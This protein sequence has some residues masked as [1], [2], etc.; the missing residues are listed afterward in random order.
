[1]SLETL[2]IK[3]YYACHFLKYFKV[4]DD[5][6]NSQ[7]GLTE[8]PDPSGSLSKEIPS[9]TAVANTMV[10]SAM[11]TELTRKEYV[12]L[13]PAQQFQIRKKAAEI[14]MAVAL[15]Y[16][17]KRHLNQALTESTITRAKNRNV[18]ELKKNPNF[19]LTELKE[20]PT[21]KRGR[22]LLIGEELD[23]QIRVYLNAIQEH[24]GV[25]NTAIA[26]AVGNDVIMKD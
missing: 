24:G 16:F 9:S 4:K 22:P 17:E 7:N 6:E 2:K 21:R 13:T 3:G 11:T 10:N 15:R 12:K 5:T 19:E 25:V 20:L 18:E 26:I 14:G 23:R 8:L 1:M